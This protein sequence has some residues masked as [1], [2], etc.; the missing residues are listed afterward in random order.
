VEEQEQLSCDI[1]K[2]RE[3]IAEK[4]RI[5]VIFLGKEMPMTEGFIS[6]LSKADQEGFFG[7]MEL[8]IVPVDNQECDALAEREEVEVLP[9]IKVYSRG[10]EVGKVVPPEGDVGYF[11]TIGQLIDLSGD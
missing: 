3:T 6:A 5:A 7:Q 2:F 4:D 10:E 8:A 1:N 11:Q 9:T